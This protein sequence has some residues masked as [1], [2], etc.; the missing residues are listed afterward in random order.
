MVTSDHQVALAHAV[1]CGRVVIE[2]YLDGPELSLFVV[3]DGA[4][5]VPLPLAQDYKRVGDGDTGPNTGGMGAYAPISWAPPDL[6]PTVMSTVVSPVLAAM[7][8]R[9]NP[10]TGLLYV[11]LALGEMQ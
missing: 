9:G 2:E 5:A 11:G 6:V 3:T 10:F 7:D 1:D 4:A 8:R